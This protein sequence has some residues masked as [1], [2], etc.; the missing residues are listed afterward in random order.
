MKIHEIRD[1]DLKPYQLALVH[2]CTDTDETQTSSRLLLVPCNA[3]GIGRLENRAGKERAWMRR[4]FSPLCLRPKHTFR[5][6]VI[7]RDTG[8]KIGVIDDR[9]GDSTEDGVREAV[10][11]YLYPEEAARIHA[12]INEIF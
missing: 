11:A 8:A 12:T 2:H 3:S 10:W 1:I 7:K 6:E 4:S 9:F 5:V